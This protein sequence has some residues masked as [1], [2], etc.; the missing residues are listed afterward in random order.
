MA[1][2]QHGALLPIHHLGQSNPFEGDLDKWKQ[3]Q[4]HFWGSWEPTKSGGAK[5]SMFLG[6]RWHR[7][8]VVGQGTASPAS[9]DHITHRLPLRQYPSMN[10]SFANTLNPGQ[11][12][13]R[14]VDGWGK[15]YLPPPLCFC[16]PEIEWLWAL[17]GIHEYPQAHTS[18]S[19]TMH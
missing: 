14:S 1:N 7:A 10:I 2:V 5:P 17:P 12:V 13:P 11:L 8:D 6:S 15:D 4:W 9:V 19:P 18:P 3:M 16:A